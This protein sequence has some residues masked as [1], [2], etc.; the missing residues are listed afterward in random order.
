M[1]GPY[2]IFCRGHSGGRI[3]CEAFI[4]NG[5]DMGTVAADRKD[6]EFFSINNPVIYEL[7]LNAYHY[8]TALPEQKKYLQQLMKQCLDN[9]IEKEIK[10]EPF[11]W[12]MGMS[13]F[14]LPLVLDTFPQAKV[15]H[16]IRDGRDVM[17][18][19][20]EAR[21]GGNNLLN[22]LN[23]LLVFGQTHVTH[24]AGHQLTPET[25]ATY[26]NE[27]EILHW[28]TAVSYGLQGRQYPDRYLEIKYETLCQEPIATCALLFD[29]LQQP[30]LAETK[31]WLTQAVHGVRIGKWR[32]L[33]AAQLE[34]P[35]AIA[36][37][38]LEKLGY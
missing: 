14:L 19:R 6:T 18:S 17:L 15:I 20:L 26:R 10:T 30:F 4:R 29:F 3:L 2:P 5:I 13:V 23:Q 38:L 35:L 8:T 24:F 28:V 7:T 31:S 27:L 1:I 22:P 25:I 34:K 36:A 12:K 16:L 21:F 11:G 37:E 33:P 9:Y 32:S